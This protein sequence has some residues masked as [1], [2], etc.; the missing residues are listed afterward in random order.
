VKTEDQVN[1]VVSPYSVAE[2]LSMLSVGAKGRTKA[3]I[4]T[5]V[6]GPGRTIDPAERGLRR[7]D[8]IKELIPGAGTTVKVANAIWPLRSYTL[9]P[10]FRQTMTSA[11]DAT[12]AELA[13]GSDPAGSAAT[14]NDWV[15]K[16]TNGE[17][18]SLVAPSLFSGLT[19]LVLTNAVYFHGKWVSPF[20]VTRTTPEPFRLA[21]RR[22]VS[23]PT[24]HGTG[25]VS[26]GRSPRVITLPFTG[27]YELVIAV[28]STSNGASLDQAMASI[29][30]PPKSPPVLCEAVEIALPKWS[31]QATFFDLPRSL[32]GLGVT[33]AFSSAADLTGISPVAAT[34]G[35]SVSDIVH[36]A[37]IDVDEEGT[38]ATA[39]TAIVA[40][41]VS[42]PVILGDCP[43]SVAADQPFVYVIRN[44]ANSEVLFAGRVDDPSV[45]V[46]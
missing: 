31:A 3:Q 18:T 28:P 43:T 45:P 40:Q 30:S 6:A 23:V 33:D 21:N 37:T 42:S 15:A 12:T 22:S 13:Y 14:I 38:T 1:L 9:D 29:Q 16:A 5:A 41:A 44:T 27:R 2:A 35:L 20:N 24:M 19:R 4:D 8:L 26:K 17:I 7:A 34:E 36:Q 11:F 25:T 39:A 10:S 32:Q 46:G